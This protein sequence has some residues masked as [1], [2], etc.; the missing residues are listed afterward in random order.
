MS[1]AL[2]S[3]SRF[4]SSQGALITSSSVISAKFPGEGW[5]ICPVSWLDLRDLT[6]RSA[7][8]H[9]VDCRQVAKKGRETALRIGQS[10]CKLTC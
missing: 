6:G 8:N 2:S 1:A 5:K 4:S 10:A 3:S 7:Q 9:A